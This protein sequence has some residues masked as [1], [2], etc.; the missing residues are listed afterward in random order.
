MHSNGWFAS[1]GEVLQ[2]ALIELADV[3]TL[4]DGDVLQDSQRPNE[5]L[6]CILSGG[7]RLHHGSADKRTLLRDCA[8]Y[9]WFGERALIDDVPDDVV[10]TAIGETSIAVISAE[11][12][13]AW[14]DEHPAHWRDIARLVS[15]R[16]RYGTLM[17]LHA[18]A[19]PLE[20]RIMQ[21]LFLISASYGMRDPP[22]SRV[23]CSQEDLASMVGASRPSVTSALNRLA[24][25]G[26]L[27]LR[28]GEIH[29]LEPRPRPRS[30]GSRSVFGDLTA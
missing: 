26:L 7:V 8:C 10:A 17:L 19:L 11:S 6:C 30:S 23:R 25:R 24:K 12:I 13:T 15:R 3:R 1:C 4:A 16:L 21:R 22:S 27:K 20:D 9:E 14:L 18:T 29:L 2:Q 28:Y 5:G